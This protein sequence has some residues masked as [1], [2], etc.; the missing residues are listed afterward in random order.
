LGGQIEQRVGRRFARFW[1]KGVDLRSIR[2]GREVWITSVRQDGAIG[3]AVEGA[4]VLID[5]G[6][7]CLFF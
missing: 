5:L 2:P 1:G 4:V 7:Y 3:I 6:G